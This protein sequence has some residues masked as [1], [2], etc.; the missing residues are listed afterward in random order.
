M[1]I[2]HMRCESVDWVYTTQ[3]RDQS[4]ALVSMTVNLLAPQKAQNVL[5]CWA[6]VSPS[7]RIVLYVVN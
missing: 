6:N 2:K 5:Y 3:R 1:D 4:Q 7:R